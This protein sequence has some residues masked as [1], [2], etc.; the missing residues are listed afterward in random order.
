MKLILFVCDL[1]W[2]MVYVWIRELNW[3]MLEGSLIWYFFVGGWCSF[4]M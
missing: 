4:K 2:V 3:I 1:V